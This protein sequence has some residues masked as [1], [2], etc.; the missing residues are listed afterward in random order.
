MGWYYGESS[1]QA[2]IDELTKGWVAENGNQ[3]RTLAKSVRGN[4]LY[5][6]H[7]TLTYENGVEKSERYIGVYLLGKSGGDWGYKPQD[8][9]MGPYVYDCP[10]YFFDLAPIVPSGY[11]AQWREKVRAHHASKATKK[12]A[13]VGDTIVF[14]HGVNFAG[15][16]LT[17]ETVTMVSGTKVYVRIN[18]YNVRVMPKHIERIEHA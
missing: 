15:H 2:V 1:K 13:K 4:T 6:V 5:T 8:E 12:G 14:R 3:H 18:G 9:S 7:E 11:A 10:L 16:R 17:S